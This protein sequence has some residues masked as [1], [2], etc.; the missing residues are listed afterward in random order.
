[1]K[2]III[3]LA[4]LPD[5]ILS[6]LYLRLFQEKNSLL[7]FNIHGLFYNKKEIYQNLVDPQTWMTKDQF[8]QF[9]EYFLKNNY[10]FVSPNDIL[11]GLINNKKYA[12][13]TF[14]DG[15][16]NNNYALSILKKHQIPALFFISTNHIKQNKCFWWDIL[17]RERIK[18]GLSKKEIVD[19]QK[20]LKSKKSEE[21]EQYLKEKFGEKAFK[22]KSDIDRPFTINE[23][24]N[25]SKEKY[26][27]L[28]NHT[29]N[30]AIL[31]NYPSNEIKSQII[32]AQK[33]IYEVTGTT[34]KTLSYPNG[35]YSD[36]IIKISKEL[37]IQI[38]T[39]IEYKKNK[40]PINYQT[41][42][43]INLGRFDLSGS[44][45]IIKQ[46]KLFRSDIL[47]YPRVLNLLK[48]K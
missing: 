5:L 8:Q 18:S 9:V 7:I 43:F 44:N 15:Y 20:Q 2:K 31:T 19:E 47:L 14:D 34:P 39:T 41:N 27:F 16:Y 40:L 26:V 37:G 17:Y 29:S 22:P 46:C 35:N 42:D 33:F 10:T 24:K 21:I 36:E 25:F 23:L 1:L 4:K 12:M 30:H 28:G 11:K 3:T 32:E 45:N 38:G 6:D 13:I 48:Q